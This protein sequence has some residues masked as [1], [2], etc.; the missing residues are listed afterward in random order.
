VEV[1]GHD[2]ARYPGSDIARTVNRGD[3]TIHTGGQFE[4]HLLA[5][6]ILHG[7]VQQGRD[8]FILV[9]AVLQGDASDRQ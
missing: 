6:C 4:S 2:A 8:R 7:V 5:T 9:R 3:H 1:L